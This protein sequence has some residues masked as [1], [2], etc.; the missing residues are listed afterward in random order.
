MKRDCIYTIQN[1]ASEFGGWLGILFGYSLHDL[2]IT[3][4]EVIA[5]LVNFIFKYDI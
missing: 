3:G 2:G 5:L 4:M 1:L